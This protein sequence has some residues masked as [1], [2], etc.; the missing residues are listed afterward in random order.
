MSFL[1][2]HAFAST[3]PSASNSP[4]CLLSLNTAASPP[5]GSLPF[6]LLHPKG[7][8]LYL[9]AHRAS[10]SFPPS[11]IL[12]FLNSKKYHAWHTVGMKELLISTVLLL[13][14]SLFHNGTVILEGQNCWHIVGLVEYPVQGVGKGGGAF[15]WLP[16][17]EDKENGN[18]RFKSSPSCF[19]L[20]PQDTGLEAAGVTS[21]PLN[22]TSFLK[23]SLET[24]LPQATKAAWGR[25][26]L[27]VP[28]VFLLFHLLS[29]FVYFP[30]LMFCWFSSFPNNSFHC[31]LPPSP[32]QSH[33]Q[34][35]VA[36]SWK[37]ASAAVHS[38]VCRGFDS[39]S[40]NCWSPVL[41]TY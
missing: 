29:S 15:G 3:F 9:W 33:P 25:I 17:Q 39:N 11:F 28:T 40:P 19:H 23:T 36:Q 12:P 2:V 5:P 30:L 18:S 32:K 27:P 16:P 10:V 7:G 4:L 37:Q 24:H 38:A 31:S 21:A 26:N 20:V 14:V 22:R 13:S 35:S 41:F 8:V 1:A 34:I 6:P